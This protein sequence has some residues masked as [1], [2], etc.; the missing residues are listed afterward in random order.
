MD[1]IKF[2]AQKC[3][4]C[5]KCM[6]TCPFGAIQIS[7]NGVVVGDNCSMC[8]LCIRNCP[9]QALHL[10]QKAKTFQKEDW[11]DFLIFV[12]QECGEIHPVAYELIGEARKM[13]AK[14]SYKVNCILI[15]GEKTA[16]NAKK[17]LQY[18]VDQVFV[19]EHPG[20]EGFK[21]DCYADAM[22]D[23]I[24][25]I[26]PSSVLIGATALGRSLA[27]CLSTRFHTGL[28]ADC[29]TLDSDSS[30]IWRQYHGSDFHCQFQTAI[31]YRTL[32]RHG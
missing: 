5:G 28:T 19:Y 32:P 29:T 23:C 12:E 6:A 14:V 13:A 30:G 31:C 4:L 7:E 9:E 27:P 16:E 20:F 10:E 2:D 17:L 24:S 26:K 25:A 15:G 21:A 8:K 22:S 1:F 11:R 18:G 3:T